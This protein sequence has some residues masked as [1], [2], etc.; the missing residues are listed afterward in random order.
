[1][2]LY[3][4][5]DTDRPLYVVA[6]NYGEAEYV[7]RKI[8]AKENELTLEEIDPPQGISFICEDMDLVLNGDHWESYCL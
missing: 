3:L 8:V 2:P 6:K 7:W 1:M 4:I 5:Q